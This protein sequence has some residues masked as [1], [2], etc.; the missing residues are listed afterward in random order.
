MAKDKTVYTCT[1]CGGMTPKWQGKCPHC[2]AWNTLIEGVADPA[3]AAR[4][5]FASLAPPSEVA[6]LADIEAAEVPRTPTG[7][8]E[9]DRVLGGGIVEGGVILIGGD[10]GIGKS[11]LLLQA[12]DGL[13]RQGVATLYVTGEE[14]GRRSPCVRAGWAWTGRR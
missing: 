14:S 7:I 11:T 3:G 2:G 4:N 8:D 5:R 6:V 9:L 13:Q 12:L 10:P 1:E